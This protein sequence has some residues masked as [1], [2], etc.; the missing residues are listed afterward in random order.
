MVL[1]CKFNEFSK[2]KAGSILFRKIGK[3][4]IILLNKCDFFTGCYFQTVKTPSVIITGN[5]NLVIFE[6]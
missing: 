4:F 1:H 5:E 3:I 6:N 2:T